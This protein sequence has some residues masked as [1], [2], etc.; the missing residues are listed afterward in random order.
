MPTIDHAR[1]QQRICADYILNEGPDIRG[2]T[3][4]MHDWFAEEFLMEQEEP[5][6]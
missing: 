4:G 1:Q 6:P 3:L 5:H 2:A